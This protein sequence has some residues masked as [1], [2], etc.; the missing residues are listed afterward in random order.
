MEMDILQCALDTSFDPNYLQKSEFAKVLDFQG[1]QWRNFLD[2]NDGPLTEV[3][4]KQFQVSHLQ[5]VQTID[6]DDVLDFLIEDGVITSE[7]QQVIRNTPTKEDSVREMKCI[8]EK[9]GKK[10]ILSLTR[11]MVLTS[12]QYR[13]RYCR[14]A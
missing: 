5:M 11:A 10:G 12:P 4:K 7:Q 9:R 13:S 1:S 8:L 2:D 3:Q 14:N 6:I